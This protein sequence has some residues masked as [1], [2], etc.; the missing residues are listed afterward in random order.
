MLITISSETLQYVF[1]IKYP[2]QFQ[3]DFTKVK[4]LIDSGNKVNAMT[5]AYVIKLDLII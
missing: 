1:Y 5:L 2:I 3:E 4:V